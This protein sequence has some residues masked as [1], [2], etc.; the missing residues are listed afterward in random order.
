M[1]FEE[2]SREELERIW[3]RENTIDL[4]NARLSRKISKVLTVEH[5]PYEVDALHRM[6]TI[7]GNVERIGDHAKNIAGYAE[8]MMEQGLEL[9]EQAK[10][11]LALMR[12]SCSRAMGLLC[13][14]GWMGTE[15]WFGGNG[16]EEIQSRVR[17]AGELE[18]YI[19]DQAEEFRANQIRRMGNGK[20][21][22][23]TSIL[24]SEILTDF[25]RIGD[26]VLNIARAGRG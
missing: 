15:E 25:E 8:T 13:D 21:H 9:S 11:E 17:L 22:V 20:C 24:Y 2:K 3:E 19:D 14:T 23:E 18:Q 5:S 6:F 10:A 12:I 26:H 1:A 16:Q 7:T 4:M